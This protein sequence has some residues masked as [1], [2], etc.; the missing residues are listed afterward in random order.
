VTLRITAADEHVCLAVEDHGRT[1]DHTDLEVLAEEAETSL[2]HPEGLELWLVRWTV[3]Y[4]DG[5][6]SVVN[7]DVPRIEVR[8]TPAVDADD[9]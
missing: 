7:D 3:L 5:E 6:I 8:L 2:T 1:I 9:E 4:S